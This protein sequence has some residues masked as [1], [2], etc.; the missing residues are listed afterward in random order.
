ME[1][2]IRLLSFA[3]GIPLSITHTTILCL[4]LQTTPGK[5]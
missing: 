2:K 4:N 3:F 5:I 1:N